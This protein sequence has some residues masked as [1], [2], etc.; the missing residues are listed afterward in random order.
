ML[1][2]Y[3]D[4]AAAFKIKPS[5]AADKKALLNQGYLVAASH[6]VMK[7]YADGKGEDWNLR[8]YMIKAQN[9]MKGH[10]ILPTDLHPMVLAT[11]RSG[12]AMK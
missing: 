1:E 8:Q 10:K 12:F 6:W 4:A 7:A 3:Y 11:Y 9:E 2:D 5:V